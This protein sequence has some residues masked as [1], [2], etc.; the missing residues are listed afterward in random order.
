MRNTLYTILLVLLSLLAGCS[1]SDVYRG[2]WKAMDRDGNKCDIV[3]DAKRFTIKDSKGMS[4]AFGY[5]Q[6]SV[7]IEN[8][9]RSYGIKL[10]DGRAFRITFPVPRNT[11]KGV[12]SLETG[13]PL[14]TIG[15]ADYVVYSDL[16]KF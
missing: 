7:R 6:N 8:A 13:E 3:F 14:Y 16:L 9:T 11:S 10:N 12:I 2:A 1:G 4:R 15:R 5:S